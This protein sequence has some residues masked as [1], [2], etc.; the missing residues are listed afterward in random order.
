LGSYRCEPDWLRL[1]ALFAS[2]WRGVPKSVRRSLRLSPD[3]ES[4]KTAIAE[5]SIACYH[6]RVVPKLAASQ[7]S[8]VMAVIQ[9]GKD[10]SLCE[11]MK[12]TFD[13]NCANPIDKSSMSRVVNGLRAANRLEPAPERKCSISGVTITPS[14][15]PA[16]QKDLF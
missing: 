10:Y 2:P 9:P 15:L 13:Q 7:N 8:R 16:T 11:L 3:E 5:T 14:K 1:S 6:N 12:L 4:M